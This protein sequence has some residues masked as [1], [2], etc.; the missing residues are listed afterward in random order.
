M[1]CSLAGV[2]LC[3]VLQLRVLRGWV[4]GLRPIQG[5]AKLPVGSRAGARPVQHE[6]AHEGGLIELFFHYYLLACR[7]SSHA[8]I[9]IIIHKMLRAQTVKNGSKTHLT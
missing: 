8:D 3:S 1:F 4:D 2:S 5:Q 7:Q 9:F 6:L